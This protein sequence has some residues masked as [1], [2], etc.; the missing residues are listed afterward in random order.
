M[1][2]YAHVYVR[3]QMAKA[4]LVLCVLFSTITF[5]FITGGVFKSF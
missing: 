5:S 3:V 2:Q 4:D 1:C